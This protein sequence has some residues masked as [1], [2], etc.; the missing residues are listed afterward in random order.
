MKNKISFYLFIA[1]QLLIIDCHKCGADLIKI[2]PG[3]IN[4]SNST[5]SKWKAESINSYSEIQIKVDNTHLKQQ[6]ILDNSG[7]EFLE[8][9][10]NELVDSFKKIIS[11]QHYS[12]DNDY[13]EKFKS[14]CRLKSFD[15]NLKKGFITNDLLIFPYIDTNQYLVQNVLTASSPCLISEETFRP[16]AG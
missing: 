2:V 14:Y 6:N 10:F 5:N 3:K 11:I 4:T 13:S 9:I 16:M 1:F 12:I 7:L 15:E 8:E